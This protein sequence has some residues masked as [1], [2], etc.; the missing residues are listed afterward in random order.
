MRRIRQLLTRD[1]PTK[2][3]FTGDSITHGKMHTM[4]WRDYTELFSE[5]VRFEL[6]RSRD[7]VIKTGVGGGKIS[8]IANDLEWKVFQFNPDCVSIMIGANDCIQGPDNIGAFTETYLKTI[9]SIHNKTGA[10]ILL[11]T[12]NW[13]QPTGK[14]GQEFLNY[15]PLYIEAVRK[16][17]EISQVPIVDHYTEWVKSGASKEWWIGKGCHP[18]EY[19]HRAIARTIFRELD[20]WDDSSWTCQLMVPYWNSG[21]MGQF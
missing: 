5:R 17:A 10:S 7:I 16:I 19:G 9:E 11:H 21:Q 8:T 6:G 2:W 18:N 1:E 4:G 20:I 13:A 3:V 15:L 14:F 12:P